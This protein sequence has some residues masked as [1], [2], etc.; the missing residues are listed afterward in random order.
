[1][2]A[3]GS[4]VTDWWLADKDGVGF[5]VVQFLGLNEWRYFEGGA[6]DVPLLL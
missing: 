1:M 5:R 2:G 6:R 3:A 4:R